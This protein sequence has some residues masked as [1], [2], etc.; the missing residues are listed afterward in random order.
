MDELMPKVENWFD[1]LTVHKEMLEDRHRTDSYKKAIE[2]VVQEGDI[3]VDVGTGTGILSFFAAQAKAKRVY[4]IEKMNIINVAKKIAQK[5]KLSRQIKFIQGDSREISIGKEKADVM[6][7]E[8]IGHFALDENMLDSIIDARKRFLKKNGKI[9]PKTIKMFFAPVTAKKMYSELNY[10]KKK[11][12]QID[13]SP[14]FTDAVNNVYIEWFE[15]EQF[16]ADHKLFQNIDLYSV[17]DVNLGGKI[18][19]RIMRSGRLHGFVGWFEAYLTDDIRITTSPYEPPT[20]WICTFFP[21]AEPFEVMEHDRI[22]FN[23]KNFSIGNDILWEWSGKVF[24]GTNILLTFR[25]KTKDYLVR[26]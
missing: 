9:I 12:H 2:Q 3:V 18:D 14:A 23:F 8:V 24:R 25:Q 26:Q 6:V 19:F 13:F 15:P 17:E 7:S 11:L 16:L 20:H 21:I 5:N 10:W 22:G 1:F 4:A